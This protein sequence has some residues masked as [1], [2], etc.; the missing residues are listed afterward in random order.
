MVYTCRIETYE[1]HKYFGW[2]IISESVAIKKEW[3]ANAFI[4]KF[5]HKCLAMTC[6][7]DLKDL[8]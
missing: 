5:D 3:S 2:L 6:Q 4:G 8:L 1:R 7:K